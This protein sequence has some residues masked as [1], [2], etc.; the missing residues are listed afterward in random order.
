L[1][2]LSAIND[3]EGTGGASTALIG[4]LTFLGDFAAVVDEVH[5]GCPGL[6]GARTRSPAVFSPGLAEGKVDA[7]ASGVATSHG[8][9]R[10][11]ILRKRRNGHHQIPAQ[12]QGQV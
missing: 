7:A 8:R 3:D 6:I 9:N 4:A 5:C 11:K 2:E 12:R 1:A 10:M